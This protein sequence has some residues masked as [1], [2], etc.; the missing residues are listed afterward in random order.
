MSSA[1]DP[2]PH[3]RVVISV[4]NYRTAG[5]TVQCAESV[6]RDLGD[7]D[8]H[9]V[10]VDNHSGD[11]SADEIAAW[12]DTRPDKGK[13]TLVRSASNT[14]FSGGHNQGI[15]A[16]TADYY[17]VL[18]SDA[19][20]QPGFFTAILSAAD[21]QPDKGLFAPRIDYDDGSQQISCFRF[22][23]PASELIRAAQSGPVSRLLGARKVPLTMPP[24]PDQIEW[25]S[26]ACILLRGE[27]VK[28]LGPMDEGY[29]LYFED[30]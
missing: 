4:I 2:A 16:R 10:I 18:N 22:H 28:Q 20:V 8:G 6:L 24:A 13:V 17:L 12:I 14:G 3:H 23:S 15:C 30:V 21:A 25:A 27:M 26:F 1:L 7:H 19:I 5:L 9:L 29:F 11:G